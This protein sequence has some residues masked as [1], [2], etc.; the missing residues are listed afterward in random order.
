VVRIARV[1]DSR[2]EAAAIEL[3]DFSSNIL[4]L[5]IAEKLEEAST[6]VRPSQQFGLSRVEIARDYRRLSIA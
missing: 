3:D 4:Y 6:E 2:A 5:G 1:D